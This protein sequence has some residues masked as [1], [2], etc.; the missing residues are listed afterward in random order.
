VS[1]RS[2]SG[3]IQLI[4]AVYRTALLGACQW[5]GKCVYTPYNERE[6]TT[7]GKMAAVTVH[8]AVNEFLSNRWVHFGKSRRNGN[9]EMSMEVWER[10]GARARG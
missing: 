5:G 1:D 7:R 4:Q 10:D 2:E 6:T 9:R 8:R 3:I